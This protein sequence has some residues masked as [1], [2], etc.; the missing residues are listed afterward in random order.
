MRKI[1][2][3]RW[4]VGAVIAGR[5]PGG[6]AGGARFGV[7]RLGEGRVPSREYVGKGKVPVAGE[8]GVGVGRRLVGRRRAGRW[9]AGRRRAG[10]RRVGHRRAGCKPSYFPC[11]WGV[12]LD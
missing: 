9:R 4:G 8:R 2:L 1:I 11:E 12:K 5:V 7:L 10:R 3:L 6:A